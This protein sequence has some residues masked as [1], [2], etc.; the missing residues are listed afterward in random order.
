MKKI[1]IIIISGCIYFTSHA[2][3]ITGI[4]YSTDWTDVKTCVPVAGKGIYMQVSE[5]VILFNPETVKYQLYNQTD[6]GRISGIIGM[7]NYKDKVLVY[8]G[9]NLYMLQAS[10]RFKDITPPYDFRGYDAIRHIAMDENEITLTNGMKLYSYSNAAWRQVSTPDMRYSKLIKAYPARGKYI[11]NIENSSNL[12][13]YDPETKKQTNLAYVLSPSALYVPGLSLWMMTAQNIYYSS[14]TG[15][16]MTGSFK[17]ETFPYKLK[18]DLFD[19]ANHFRNCKLALSEKQEVFFVNEEMV[20]KVDTRPVNDSVIDIAFKPSDLKPVYASQDN[21]LCVYGNKVYKIS[22]YGIIAV[23]AQK[24]D[25]LFKM[26]NRSSKIEGSNWM[27]PNGFLYTKQSNGIH[28]NNG[29]DR[30]GSSYLK[31]YVLD[32]ATDGKNNYLLTEKALY[33]EKNVGVFDSIAP[34]GDNKMNA[35]AIDKSGTIWMA[36]HKGITTISKGVTTFIPATSIEGFPA[37][38]ALH[39]IAISPTGEIYLSLS[40]VYTYKD[41]K[42]VMILRSPS[43]IYNHYFDRNGNNYMAS[44]GEAYFYNGTEV[45]DMKDILK[46]AYPE[47]QNPY[48]TSIT[49]DELGRCWAI[50]NFRQEK[51][52]VV[53]D[54]GKPVNFF[55]DDKIP[56]DPTRQKIFS[57]KQQIVIVTEKGRWTIVKYK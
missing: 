8:S 43:L 52:I 9:T 35:L 6:S 12:I 27:M 54:K 24:T 46:E 10:G 45:R 21:E 1:S 36:S 57:Y 26:F 19:K 48:I 39:D 31:G 38:Q 22:S 42:M 53:L 34:A 18:W 55:A 30:S 16:K 5:G 3:T 20:L 29:K 23:S 32:M 14:V 25:T 44:I 4:E 7:A 56:V 11:W 28:H 47:K 51:G 50:V 41:K 15:K 13:M 33:K 40:N 49:V 37:N 2:Q 17:A